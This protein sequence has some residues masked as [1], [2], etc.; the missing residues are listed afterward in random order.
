MR[1]NKEK[2][3][4]LAFR[5]IGYDPDKVMSS[6]FAKMLRAAGANINTAW[7]AWRMATLTGNSAKMA[8]AKRNLAAKNIGEC[9]DK[10][11]KRHLR[12][13]VRPLAAGVAQTKMQLKIMNRMYYIAYGR[14]K[15]AFRMW[16]EELTKYNEILN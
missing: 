14:L 2:Y 16:T 6:A 9:L 1:N 8:L 5:R 4:G 10:K 15:T 13:G 7:L 11:R 12:S 3:L